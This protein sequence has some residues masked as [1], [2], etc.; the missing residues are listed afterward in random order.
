MARIDYFFSLL[1]PW[2]YLAGQ[3]L[4][5]IA[6]QYDAQ[7]SYFPLDLI[8]LFGRTGGVPLAQRPPGRV[9]YR[10]QDL[11][12]QAAK[13]G[14]KLTLNP[15]H[16]PTNAAPAS[17]A[18]IAASTAGGGDMGALCHGLMRACWA[19]ERN[20]AEDEV[21]RDCLAAAGFDPALA[22]KGLFTAADRYERNLEEAVACGVFGSP[23]YIVA[24]TDQR[25]WGQDRL[26]DLAAHLAELKVSGH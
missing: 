16:W 20:I 11:Q 23:F 7:I 15:A 26:E 3:R 22:D 17:Y 9:A 8:A 21:I 12:R 5:A 13:L 19:E 10:N 1:S 25:F 24:E 14:M 18:V 2:T 4:E 6:A